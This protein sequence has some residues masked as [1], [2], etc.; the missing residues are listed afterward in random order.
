[1]FGFFKKRQPTQ[2][3]QYIKAIYGDKPPT[4]SAD[5]T[6]AVRLAG[7]DLLRG[8]ADPDQLDTLAKALDASPIPYSTHD[9]AVSVALRT[10]KDADEYARQKLFAAQLTAR[11]TALK[12]AKE[13]K[14]VPALLGAFE[15]TL[16]ELY[17]PRAGD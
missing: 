4:E 9:L 14:L 15:T 11:L 13:A 3:D 10:F 12:W 5:V 16:Y 7:E 17:K 6:E 2:M 8:T 1:M